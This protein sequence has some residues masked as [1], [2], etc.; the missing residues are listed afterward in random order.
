MRLFSK[1]EEQKE[2]VEKEIEVT[3][4]N[5]KELATSVS[6]DYHLS[7]IK[8]IASKGKFSY[9]PDTLPISTEKELRK[10]GFK[11]QTYPSFYDIGWDDNNQEK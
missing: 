8:E 5:M 2:I 6:V 11:I 7:C 3:A 10:L 1:K 4:E 9:N